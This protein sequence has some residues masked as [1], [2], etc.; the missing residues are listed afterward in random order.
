MESISVHQR[1]QEVVSSLNLA[2]LEMS[3]LCQKKKKKTWD[4]NL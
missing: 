1:A 4:L 3:F 2:A